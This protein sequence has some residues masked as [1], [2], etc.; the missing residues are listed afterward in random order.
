MS[1]VELVLPRGATGF[2]SAGVQS[3]SHDER[4]IVIGLIHDAARKAGTSAEPPKV[5]LVQSFDSLAIART[6]RC[7]TSWVMVHNVVRVVAVTDRDPKETIPVAAHV[8]DSLLDPR[9][10]S[11]AGWHVLSRD[12]ALTPVSPRSLTELADDELE[13]YRY[14]KPATLGEVLFNHWD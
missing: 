8:I 14:W 4:R 9:A 13:Q 7:P 3:L 11:E 6:A 5:R 2:L 12:E 10:F 1:E